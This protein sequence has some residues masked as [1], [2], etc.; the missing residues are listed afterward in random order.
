L[1]PFPPTAVPG[2]YTIQCMADGYAP[3][4]LEVSVQSGRRVDVNCRLESYLSNRFE[5]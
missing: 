5:E 3:Q 4:E 1:D 2:D